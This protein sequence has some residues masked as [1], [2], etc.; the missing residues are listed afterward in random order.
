MK[1]PIQFIELLVHHRRLCNGV[2]AGIC[3]LMMAFALYAQHVLALEPCPLCVMQ[4][5]AMIATGVVFLLAFLHGPGLVGSRAYAL[6]VT[7]VAG[8]GALVA[9]RHVWL[10]N[11]PPDEVPA[12]G[13]GLDYMLDVFPLADALRMVFTGSGE[14]A[15]VKWQL[16][17][18][19]M[20]GWVL[21]SFIGMIIAAL[22]VNLPSADAGGTARSA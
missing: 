22:V 17:G 6:L 1:T 21:L 3:A 15:D 5:L 4:R 7:L 20:P 11:L 19:T 13:P 16:L 8:A 9:G 10:Q 12:C 18:L 2:L 14:C